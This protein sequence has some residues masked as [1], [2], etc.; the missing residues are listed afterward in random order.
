MVKIK[1]SHIPP[2]YKKTEVGVIPEEWEVTPLGRCVRPRTTKTSP[3]KVPADTPC[4]ELEHIGQKTGQLTSIGKAANSTSIKYEF[5]KGDVLFGRLRAYLRKYW[6]AEVNGICSTEIW[7]LMTEKQYLDSGFLFAVVQTERFIEAASVAYGT[8][9]PRTDWGVI[10]NFLIPLPPLPEQ[11]AIA[12]VLSDVDG[13]LE[14]LDGLVKKK[15]ALKTA[16]MQQLLTGKKRLPGF[17]GPWEK[18]K[19]GEI[20]SISVGVS[21][22]S[23]ITETGRYLIADMGAVS[24]NGKLISTR[25]TDLQDDPLFPGDLIMPKDDIGGGN[26]IGKTAVIR[27]ANKYVLGDHVYLLR[28]CINDGDPFFMSYM[29]NSGQINKLLKNKASGSA[30]IGLNR[31]SVEEQEIPFPSIDEQRAIARVLSDMDAEIEALEAEREKVR[32]LKQGMMQVLLRGK[33]RLVGEKEG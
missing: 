33:V 10:K 15:R 4:I 8:H 20:F 19:L 27:E 3:K 9:M 14:A 12:R 30:Q 1:D 17:T 28:L 18:R 5:R 26:I 16:A 32:Q 23:Y 2:G 22:S 13:L 29:I 25:R 7:P 6:L 11:R 24:S 21:K 31:K